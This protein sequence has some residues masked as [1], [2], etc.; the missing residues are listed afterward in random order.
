M[1]DYSTK[2]T[3]CDVDE[4]DIT[5]IDGNYT[6]IKCGIVEDTILLDSMMSRGYSIENTY[7]LSKGYIYEY[8]E[9]GNIDTQTAYHANILFEKFSKQNKRFH[10]VPLAAACLY[11]CCKKNGVAH[12]IKEI[13]SNLGSDIKGIG[14]YEKMISD[15]HH[16]VHPSVYVERFCSKMNFKFEK[17]KMIQKQL[18]LKLDVNMSCN[19]TATACAFIYKYSDH[20]INI[21]DLS[22]VSGVPKSSIK[23]AVE[24]IK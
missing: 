18:D 6:C 8:C 16:L 17:I 22:D 4:H 13:S 20:E 5:Q 15:I 2:N 1:E 9:R 10:K 7:S 12:T 11:I 21:F 24:K 23:R 19:P 14:K 3:T